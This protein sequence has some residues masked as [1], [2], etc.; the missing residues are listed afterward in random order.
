MNKTWLTLP[1]CI[2]GLQSGTQQKHS[3]Q[4]NGNE[5]LMYFW[6]QFNSYVPSLLIKY[7]TSISLPL[8]H[9]QINGENPKGK[10]CLRTS[11][12]HLVL[13]TRIY[14]CSFEFNPLEPQPP[15]SNQ[16]CQESA[17]SRDKLFF[18]KNRICIVGS[19]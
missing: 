13:F 12:K 11:D 5:C 6:E 17:G 3:H 4:Q 14:F 7:S 8:N 10:K 9:K 18:Q 15:S 19:G 1:V 16:N 2:T